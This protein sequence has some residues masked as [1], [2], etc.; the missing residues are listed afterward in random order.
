[1]NEQRPDRRRAVRRKKKKQNR[2][3]ERK[4]TKQN[5]RR[6]I[7]RRLVIQLS[8]CYELRGV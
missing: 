5:I 7:N 2:T 3:N 8:V 4:M 1:M 6:F